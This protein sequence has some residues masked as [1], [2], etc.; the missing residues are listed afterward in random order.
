M[1]PSVVNPLPGTPAPIAFC[2]TDLDAGGA[3][4][5][6]VEIVTRLDRTKWEPRVFCLG[7][8]GELCRPLAEAGIEAVCLGARRAWHIR[9]LPRLVR[10]L[11]YFRPVLLQTWLYHANIAGRIAARM[12]RVPRVVAGIR[13]AERRGRRRLR[14]D[15]A[16]QWIVDHNVC[17]SQ[18]VAEFSIREGGLKP[19]KVSVIR[20]GVD[21]ERFASAQPADLTRFGIPAESRTVVF[22]GRLDPQKNPLALVTAMERLRLRF[23]DVHAL[24]VGE[25]TLRPELERDVTARGLDEIVHLAGWQSNVPELMRAA[26]VLAV[27]SRWEGLANVALEA[28]AAG[29]PVVATDVE[30]VREVVVSGR[31]GV[32]VPAGSV[33]DLAEGLA[34]L[35]GPPEMGAAMR[36]ESQRIVREGFT[37]ERAASEYEALYGRLLES[38]SRGALRT[39]RRKS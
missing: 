6:L 14:I 18:S 28:M 1:A 39:R 16:T 8:P 21:F 10:E 12:A 27:P 38:G 32:I 13:V 20:N 5:A 17:V 15:K 19:D 25:G 23:S 34:L 9:I 30:G 3:E 26:Y 29:L 31:T 22:V 35:L 24:V 4:R 11:R 7:S 36:R 2:I 37:W 33:Q